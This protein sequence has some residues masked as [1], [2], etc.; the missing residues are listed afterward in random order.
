VVFDVDFEVA[1]V[2]VVFQLVNLVVFLNEEVENV[3]VVL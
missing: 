3:V 2:V 1:N